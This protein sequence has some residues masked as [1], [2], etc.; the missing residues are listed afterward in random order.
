MWAEYTP[1]VNGKY[2]L[3][4]RNDRGEKLIEWAE[5]NNMVDGNT[6]LKNTPEEYRHGKSSDD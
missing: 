6:F 1:G 2:G 5:V 4:Q 3:G